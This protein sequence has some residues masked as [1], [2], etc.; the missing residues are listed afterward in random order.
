MGGTSSQDRAEMT[1]AAG[2]IEDAGGKIQ[3]AQNVLSD[4]MGALKAKWIGDA[5]NAFHNAYLEFDR[6]LDKVK[7]GLDKIHGQLVDSQINY[8][9]AEEEQKAAA[10][11]FAKLL[12]SN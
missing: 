11:E 12:N 7:A 9:K 3:G 4:N 5:S 1:K 10:T 2:Q 8:T 6:E